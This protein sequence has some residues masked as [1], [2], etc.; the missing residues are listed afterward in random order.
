MIC[1]VLVSFIY[2]FKPSSSYTGE[3]SYDKILYWKTLANITF[4]GKHGFQTIQFPIIDNIYKLTNPKAKVSYTVR[5]HVVFYSYLVSCFLV[6]VQLWEWLLEQ[7]Q[8]TYH[9]WGWI[10]TKSII[11]SPKISLMIQN[12]CQ[13]YLLKFFLSY[14][15]NHHLVVNLDGDFFKD[16]QEDFIFYFNSF[17]L[18]SKLIEIKFE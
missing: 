10:P 14:L 5:L 4:F 16:F 2:T 13:E 7:H 18:T 1:I 12:Y 8:H 15:Q 9:W 3:E 6:P 11:I 17:N